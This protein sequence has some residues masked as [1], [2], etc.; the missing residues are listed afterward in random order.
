MSAGFLSSLPSLF[1]TSDEQAMWRVKMQD[2][3]QAFA[4][5]VQRWQKPIQ[6]LCARMTGDIHRGE[7]LSQETFAKIFARR[8][9]YEPAGRFATYLWRVALNNCYDEL[10]RVGRRRESTLEIVQE[11]EDSAA[12][13]DGAMDVQTPAP[14][15]ALIEQERAEAVRRALLQLAEPYRAVVVLRHY[16]GLKFREIGEVL[17]IPEGTVKSRMAEALTQLNRL[18]NNYER[19]TSCKTKIKTKREVPMI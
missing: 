7:D 11:S 18:L 5:L 12:E 2:D 8:K 6:S 17:E 4:Q 3:A 14:D 15:S 1:G 9:E 16:E 19:D 13:S 10:R